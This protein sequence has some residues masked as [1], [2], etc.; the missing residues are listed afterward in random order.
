MDLIDKILTEWAYR[1][2]DGMPNYKNPQHIIKLKES[3]E[4]LKLSK[5]F[6]FEFI[7]NLFEQKFYSRSKES[8]RIVQYTDKDNWKKGIEDGSHEKVDQ[9][10]AKKEFEKQDDEPPSTGEEPTEEPPN[11]DSEP[12]MNIKSNPMDKEDEKKETK[13]DINKLSDEKLRELDHQTTNS[14]LNL[15]L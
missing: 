7:Q 14:Q 11:Q 12:G 3:M 8:K 4:E 10:D 13:V 15:S 1:V 6:I 9:D 2:H 5:E